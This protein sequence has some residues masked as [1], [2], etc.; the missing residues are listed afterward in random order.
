MSL[1][2]STANTARARQLSEGVEMGRQPGRRRRVV[3]HI[4]NQRMTLDVEP[5]QAPG[6]VQTPDHIP[7]LFRRAVDAQMLSPPATQRQCSPAAD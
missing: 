5:L 7:D 2:D 6:Q 4:E 1:S 3:R